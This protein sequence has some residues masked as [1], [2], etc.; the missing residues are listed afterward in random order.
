MSRPGARSP[1]AAT[2]ASAV[3]DVDAQDGGAAEIVHERD[4]AL[5]GVARSSGPGG[6]RRRMR[7]P[8]PRRGTLVSAAAPPGLSAGRR[9][10]SPGRRGGRRRVRSETAS[11]PSAGRGVGSADGSGAGLGR[12]ARGRSASGCAVAGPPTG[13]IRPAG[14]T[15]PAASS[16]DEKRAVFRAGARSARNRRHTAVVARENASARSASTWRARRPTSVSPPLKHLV[17]RGGSISGGRLPRPPRCEDGRR[18]GLRRCR[19]RRAP[20]RAGRDCGISRAAS[21]IVST[22]SREDAATAV[23]RA[24]SRRRRGCRASRP[25]WTGPIAAART[26]A[27]PP[28]V[29]H[30]SPGE[31]I[32]SG[33]RTASARPRTTLTASVIRSPSVRGA[34]ARRREEFI[35]ALGAG[36][37]RDEVPARS[38]DDIGRRQEMAVGV[39]QPAGP[40][41]AESLDLDQEHRARA[42]AVRERAG[43]GRL[44]RTRPL[45]GSAGMRRGEDRGSGT[46][47]VSAPGTRL[48]DAHLE[49]GGRSSS[50]RSPGEE[51]STAPPER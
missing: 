18:E 24:R 13:H 37:H 32:E 3:D 44:G 1:R 42:V 11:A 36:R 43:P 20:A 41:L 4:L 45:A 30:H 29:S 19:R 6:Q 39:G 2:V 27:C 10:P 5:G 40:V 25:R 21:D 8:R 9:A 35:D 31:S 47:P 38:P 14:D 28:S 51:R 15:A 48:R 23:G 46:A 50:R 16:G 7:P 33:S 22:M 12:G 49:P 26:P 17:E 34:S